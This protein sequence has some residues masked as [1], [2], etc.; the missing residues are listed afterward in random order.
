MTLHR[1][2]R[3]SGAVF[4]AGNIRRDRA[5]DSARNTDLGSR[6]LGLRQIPRASKTLAPLLGED[7]RNPLTDPFA[8]ASHDDRTA[9]YGCQHNQTILAGSSACSAR[10]PLHL[11]RFATTPAGER[12]A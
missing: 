3:H 6:G 8:R 7:A 10:A 5:G 4:R 12:P 9:R 11:T 2:R 1:R